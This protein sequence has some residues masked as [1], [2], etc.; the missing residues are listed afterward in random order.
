MVA[1]GVLLH[2]TAV[3]VAGRAVLIRGRSGAGKSD[4]ALRCLAVPPGP[5]ATAPPLLVADDQVMASAH[6]D[7]VRISAPPALRGLIEVRGIGIRL[8]PSVPEA[9]LVLV[10]DLVPPEQ[11]ERLPELELP[12]VIAGLDVPRVLLAPF[13]ASAPLKLLLALAAAGT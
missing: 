7:R 10:A 12:A 2:G 3:A 6:G 11:V 8:A 9:D 5:F 4:L 13:E 1:E